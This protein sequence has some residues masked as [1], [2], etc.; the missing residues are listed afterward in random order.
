MDSTS[1]EVVKPHILQTM[2]LGAKRSGCLKM[3]IPKPSSSL[4]FSC[5]S[6]LRPINTNG[7]RGDVK[8]PSTVG[9]N[10]LKVFLISRPGLSTPR[11][12][13]IGARLAWE[14]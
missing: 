11:G 5:L 6:I 2:Q 13:R 7:A 3:S 1:R 4:N 9:C 8:E 14:G 10:P 12:W